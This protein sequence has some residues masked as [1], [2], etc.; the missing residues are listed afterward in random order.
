MRSTGMNRM[1]Q[2][3]AGLMNAEAHCSGDGVP[4]ASPSQAGPHPIVPLAWHPHK[5]LAAA[6]CGDAVHVFDMSAFGA[7]NGN[8][9]NG[10]SSSSHALESAGPAVAVLE[11]ELQR[12]PSCLA[13]RPLSGSILAV[14]CAGGAAIWSVGGGA[15]APV[16]G[17]AA[18][19]RLPW[20]TFLKCPVDGARWVLAPSLPGARKVAPPCFV[21]IFLSQAYNSCVEPRRP[22]AGGRVPRFRRPGPV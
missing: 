3:T 2:T 11:H 13:W 14:G 8:Y 10:S 5:S 4:Q 16:A 1:L 22:P 6:A 18:A 12:C 7:G 9:K 19:G 21:T 15:R 20:M 17:S